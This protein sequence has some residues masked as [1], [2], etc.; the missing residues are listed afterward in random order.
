MDPGY[1]HDCGHLICQ[2]RIE[3]QVWPPAAEVCFQDERFAQPFE[4][5]AQFE[6]HVFNAPTNRVTWEVHSLDGGAGAGSIDA[7]GLYLAPPKGSLPYG[8][9]DIVVATAV[10]D[11]FRRAYARVSVVGLGPAPPPPPRLEVC[12]RRVHLYY[13][14]GANNDYIDSSNT[15]QLFR[16]LAWNASA[17]AVQW[18]VD[19]GPTVVTGSGAEYL[20]RLSGSGSPTT[21]HIQA[22]LD[23]LTDHAT[24]SLLN[25]KWP[26]IV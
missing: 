26:G 20:Y 9:T 16:A 23:G 22:A 15:M 25:Y 18:S 1:G 8:F 11:P 17:S 10:D 5:T 4:A 12:P 3:V 6:A 19:G 13:P 21:F 14:A 24:V 2:H 7:G